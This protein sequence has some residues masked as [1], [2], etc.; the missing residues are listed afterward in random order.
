M[1]FREF[2]FLTEST[3]VQY[4]VL[5]RPATQFGLTYIPLDEKIA[6]EAEE[7][8]KNG[9]ISKI[10]FLKKQRPS[11]RALIDGVEYLSSIDGVF[12]KKKYPLSGFKG[13][14]ISQRELY[15]PDALKKYTTYLKRYPKQDTEA[16]TVKGKPNNYTV[17]D[18]HHRME[19]YKR[20]GRTEIPVWT[21]A[22]K[23]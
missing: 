17:I 21:E 11:F 23:R 2:I 14:A 7:K 4:K 8:F 20:A 18:G 22:P 19:A 13:S 1:N 12:I 3:P 6:K 16:I 9:L 5:N 15:S 10:Q